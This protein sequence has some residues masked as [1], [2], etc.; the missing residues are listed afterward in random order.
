MTAA[1]RGLTA[2]SSHSSQMMYALRAQLFV[3]IMFAHGVLLKDAMVEV[4]VAS[5]GLECVNCE[6]SCTMRRLVDEKVLWN[7]EGNL[8]GNELARQ[9]SDVRNDQIRLRFTCNGRDT[10][11]LWLE[12]RKWHLRYTVMARIHLVRMVQDSFCNDCS[13]SDAS[14]HKHQAKAQPWL[15]EK[16]ETKE[17]MQ[18]LKT[19]STSTR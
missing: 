2:T 19:P 7:Q 13:C 16:P 12:C 14:L 3:P 6:L 17:T 18:I 11:V 5:I 8:G 9:G 10:T 1:R 4:L 15:N